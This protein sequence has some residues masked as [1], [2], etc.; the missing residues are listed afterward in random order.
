LP[1][2]LETCPSVTGCLLSADRLP[3]MFTKTKTDVTP[4]ILSRVFDA[5]QSCIE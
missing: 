1:V 4:A 2:L 5:R 3:H